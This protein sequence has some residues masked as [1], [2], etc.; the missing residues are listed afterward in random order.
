[1]STKISPT[2]WLVILLQ[3]GLLSCYR[4]ED[5][6]TKND[7]R[8]LTE[9]YDKKIQTIIDDLTLEEKIA[10]LHGDG[11]FWSAGMD[12]YGIPEVQ[13]TDGPLGIRE[14][15]QRDSWNPLGLTTDSSTFFPTSSALAATWNVELAEKYGE[16]IGQEARARNKDILLA[17]AINIMRTPLCGRNYEYFTEDPFLNASMAVPYVRGAQRQDI[18][19]CVKHFAVN[20]QET[21]RSTV[22][23]NTSERALREIYLA[24]FKAAVTDGQAY[25]VMGA[26]NKYR[27]EYLCENN[28]L[29]NTILKDEW[30]FKGAV[31]SDW[32]A[33]HNTIASAKNGLDV[34]MGTDG[35]YDNYYFAHPLIEAVKNGQVSETLINDK[36]RRVL[37]VIYNCRK[38]DPLR[39][40]GS[41]NTPDH[42]E[43]VYKVASEAIVLLKN[44]E[45]LL[46]L[47]VSPAQRI[48]VIGDNA[49]M[50]FASG[51]FGAGVKAKY[52]VTLL[53]GLM[54]RLGPKVEIRYAQ[55]YKEQYIAGVNDN[56]VYGKKIDPR[57][58]NKLINEAIRIARECD[59]AIVAVGS[60]RRVDSEGADRADMKLPFG[61][62]ELIR[63]VKE[64][65]PNT[66]VVIIAGGP[67][68]LTEVNKNTSAI[69]WTWFNGSEGGNA[70][71][72]VILGKVNPSGK[73]PYTIP[74]KLED[75]PAHA[76]N[77]F[78]G[79]S[80]NVNYTEDILVGY[81]WF[82]TKGIEPMYCF[83][84]GLSYTT[85]DY[86]DVITD[87]TVYSKGESVSVTLSLKNT[88]TMSGG[89]VIQCYVQDINP[90]IPKPKKE[91]KA[92]KKVFLQPGE[93]QKVTLAIGIKDLA[94]YNESTGTWIIEDGDYDILVGSSSRDI[95]GE[96]RI[97][98][99]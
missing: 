77:A 95:R 61:Q 17:P 88:G 31:I 52:E 93:E 82:D 2:L 58:D 74:K 41:I 57:P 65:N 85:F 90:R 47:T 5:K 49:T 92:F 84:H 32:G 98:I 29:L 81:R 14:E 69:L 33:V 51:G 56:V 38:T 80:F 20:N 76:L 55:G 30:G 42:S 39:Q 43:L 60:N 71:A 83:G 18:A 53:Q 12:R 59:Y 8:H 89:E 4:Q 3:I 9:L 86:N 24:G 64:A 73:L 97:T 96:K 25:T 28:H 21:N 87:K 34:E 1:M 67:F 75:S 62:D 54:N 19:V 22:S 99:K 23:A 91:L 35:P 50:T 6:T 13:Y 10:L 79:D 36:V 46:P 48:A 26:Y 44:S 66:V 7:Y 27:G 94:Y 11:K 16:A 45:G 72:D 37:R 63:V 40:K 68:D 70:L 15:I 78:P